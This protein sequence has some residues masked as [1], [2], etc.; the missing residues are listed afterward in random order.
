MPY[1]TRRGFSL[2]ELLIAMVLLGI[3]TLGCTA[4]S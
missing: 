1:L 4:R 2:V 3:V